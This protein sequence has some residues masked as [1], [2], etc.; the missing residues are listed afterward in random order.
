M[1]LH[2]MERKGWSKQELDHAQKAID[3]AEST[4]HQH[5]L[6]IERLHVVLL[7]AVLSLG[8]IGVTLLLMPI[9]IFD[10]LLV[11]V[12]LLFLLG[13]CVGLLYSH[14]ESHHEL[15]I[16]ALCVISFIGISL[17]AGAFGLKPVQLALPYLLGV[18]GAYFE[19][20]HHGLA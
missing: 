3:H 20:R 1:H 11:S 9:L 7:V 15:G 16:T 5:V 10:M 14:N 19:R 13:V 4:K 6:L 12:P 17:T 2:R 18:V 8:S